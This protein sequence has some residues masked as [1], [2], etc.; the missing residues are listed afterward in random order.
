MI[1]KEIIRVLHKW[2][3]WR[4]DI[5]T[6]KE[7]PK[8]VNA[9]FKQRDLKEV[10]I[11]T[12]VRRS[13]KSTILLQTLKKLI[14]HGVPA[15]NILYV[16]FEEP[17]FQG[18]LTLAFLLQ[19]YAAYIEEFNP[20]GKIYVALDEVQWV[21]VWEKFVRGPYDRGENIKFYVTGS[22]SR[23][24]SR[25]YGRVLT[26]RTFSNTVWPLSFGE[27]LAFK[28]ASAARLAP[29]APYTSE[30]KH[31]FNEYLTVG[32]FP[33]AVLS[34]SDEGEHLL[35]EY[36]DAIVEKD[37]IDRYGIRVVRE[38]KQFYLFAFARI[39]LPISG[40]AAQKSLHISQPTANKFLQYAQD[41]YLF[42]LAPFFSYSLAKQQKNPAKL[43]CA[44]AGIYRAIAFAFSPNLGRAFENVVAQALQRNGVKL[45]YWRGKH[46]VDF[47]M[48]KGFEVDRLINV[49]WE[50]EAENRARELAGLEEAMQEFKVSNGEIITLGY[51]EEIK[52]S[53]GTI[54]VKNFFAEKELVE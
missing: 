6:G 25:E 37:I 23:L 27:F 28:G 21:P 17:A 13:G 38:L 44:D 39:G 7:R 36:Y 14:K 31:Y 34:A 8:Y 51:P 53:S 35:K 30:L 33:R 3:F 11:V 42:S 46:E 43:Y 16:N 20:Q 47:V 12:G 48:R 54:R 10:S 40:Y 5:V 32:G 18:D 26:G 2:N 24:L 45:Y 41:V 15:Q 4:Q 9:L 29:G 19:L 22:S 1:N 50:L 49:C 52:V